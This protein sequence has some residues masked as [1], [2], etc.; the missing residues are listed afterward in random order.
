MGAYDLG[1]LGPA[2]V[3]SS[4]L[5]GLLEAYKLKLSAAQ[6]QAKLRQSGYNAAGTE[7]TALKTHQ[8]TVDAANTQHRMALDEKRREFETPPKFV[9]LPDP[10]NPGGYINVGTAGGGKI[11]NLTRALPKAGADKKAG[12]LDSA[13]AAYMALDNYQRLAGQFMP[14]SSNTM[15]TI[16]T[17]WDKVRGV[18]QKTS[19]QA[20]LEAVAGDAATLYATAVNK[21]GGGRMTDSEIHNMARAM[22][23]NGVGQ[24]QE[25][26][27]G[28][29]GPLKDQLAAKLGVTRGEIEDYIAAQAAG[30]AGAAGPM[31]TLRAA[32]PAPAASPAGGSAAEAELRRR[33]VIP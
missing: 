17:P 26:I 7:M 14:E 23:G 27:A 16:R 4:G 9:T 12:A 2:Q 15:A 30:K 31:Q 20:N 21:A 8:M 25:N 10:N 29:H 33:G 11:T 28:K 24:T 13:A 5:Q 1:E 18:V 6:E 22:G 3:V 32:L 19:P